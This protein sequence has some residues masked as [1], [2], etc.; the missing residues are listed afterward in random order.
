MPVAKADCVCVL[1]YLQMG[2]IDE[3]ALDRLALVTELTKRIRVRSRQ[4]PQQP[5][6]QG[7]PGGVPGSN[8]VA[9]DQ[10]NGGGG[11]A[12]GGKGGGQGKAQ[13]GGQEGARRGGWGAWPWSV[14]QKMLRHI[15][16]AG[17]EM[18]GRVEL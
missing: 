18:R 2:G 7:G 11:R 15:C 3:A 14:R 10:A 13:T 12:G 4:Q 1:A 17:R 9:A 8:D 16:R 5:Q 6:Q